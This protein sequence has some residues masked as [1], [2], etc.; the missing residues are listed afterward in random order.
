MR[1]ELLVLSIVFV[2]SISSA[3]NIPGFKFQNN[4]YEGIER[5]EETTQ[6]DTESTQQSGKKKKRVKS[7]DFLTLFSIERDGLV[8]KRNRLDSSARNALN[9]L[10]EDPENTTLRKIYKDSNDS[11]SILNPLI[12]SLSNEHMKQYLQYSTC[13]ILNFEPKSSR[14]FFDLLYNEE[15]KRFKVLNNTGFNIGNSSG[16]IYTELV[17]G[18]LTALRVSLGVMVSSSSADSL[19]TAKEEEAYQRLVSNGGNTVLNF[20]YPLLYV[21]SRNNQFNLIS[22]LKAR[23]TA[24]FKEFGTNTEDFA[25]SI[26]VGADLYWDAALTNNR[27]RIFGLINYNQFFGNGEFSNNLGVENSNFSFAQLTLGLVF[28]NIKLSF[29]VLTFSSERSLENK[30]IVAGGQVLH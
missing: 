25:G 5:V 20:E 26:S 21:H 17:S 18:N 8:A 7:K 6:S 28:D 16:S 4:P 30:N 23:G 13:N 27:M 2:T 24:D 12:D 11:I 15:G 22:R 29:V 19:A 3:Q 14:A 9:R 10:K 1:N